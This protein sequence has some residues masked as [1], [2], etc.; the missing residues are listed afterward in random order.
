MLESIRPDIT[1]LGELD[2]LEF[3]TLYWERRDTDMR[4]PSTYNPGVK[5]KKAKAKAKIQ[6]KAKGKEV[7]LTALKKL[8]PEILKLLKKAGVQ[9]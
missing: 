7:T 4:K 3:F 5:K 1:L 9:V 8:D 6:V 2:Q